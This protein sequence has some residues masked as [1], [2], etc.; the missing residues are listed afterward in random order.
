MKNTSDSNQRGL[1]VYKLNEVHVCT[2]IETEPGFWEIVSSAGKRRI[3]S[4][5]KAKKLTDDFMTLLGKDCERTNVLECSQQILTQRFTE[6]LNY[7][8]VG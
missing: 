4:F 1:S 7:R 3:G 5:D 2:L 8:M 6:F